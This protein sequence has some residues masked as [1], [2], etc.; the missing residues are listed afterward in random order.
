MRLL[1]VE[2][3]QQL[4]QLIGRMLER[5]RYEVDRA[6]DGETGLELAL[7]GAYDTIILDRML[8]RLEGLDVLREMRKE[9]INTPVLILSARREVPQRVEGLDVGA[10]DY[11]GKPFAFD[12]LFARVRALTRRRSQEII[13]DILV[14][15][16]VKLDEAAR[17]VTVSGKEVHLSPREFSLLEYLMRNSGQALSRDQIVEHVW[18]Y[19]A[20]PGEKAVELYV[21][22]LRRKLSQAGQ[23]ASIR[24]V[25]G[26]GYLIPH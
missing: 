4:A 12:E 2:D 7:T 20:D 21:H 3:E 9:E 10:D 25:R 15:G 13:P 11:L 17:I 14:A 1:V 16:N 19:D 26:Q 24:T 5:E 23:P 22:Y 6:F 8:P 18:G